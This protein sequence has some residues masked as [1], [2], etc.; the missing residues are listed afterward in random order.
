VNKNTLLFL[1]INIVLVTQIVIPIINRQVSLWT[2]CYYIL[3]CI[4]WRFTLW[5]KIRKVNKHLI[6]YNDLVFITVF[7]ITGITLLWYIDLNPFHFHYDEF[8]HA[9]TSYTLPKLADIDWFQGYPQDHVAQYPIIFYLLQKPFL[10][11]FGPSVTSVRMSTWP[12]IIGIIVYI[13]LLVKPIWGSIIAKLVVLGYIFFPGNLY[14]SSY[15]LHNIPS[16]LCLMGVLYH[17]YNFRKTNSSIHALWLGIWNALSLLYNT[18]SYIV[19]F[20]SFLLFGYWLIKQNTNYFKLQIIKSVLFTLIILFPFMVHA[21]FVHNYFTERVGQVNIFWGSRTD[22]NQPKTIVGGLTYTLLNHLHR[23]HKALYHPGIGGL[24]GYDFGRQSFFNKPDYCLILIGFIYVLCGLF[25]HRKY[26]YKLLLLFILLPIIFN[27]ILT[28]YP[29]AFHRLSVIYS[30]FAIIMVIPFNKILKIIKYYKF[31]L[32]GIFGSLFLLNFIHTNSMILHDRQYY[33]YSISLFN[34]LKSN[35]E[36]GSEIVISFSAP[37]LNYL[38]K[39][40]FFRTHGAYTFTNRSPEEIFQT[41]NGEPLILFESTPEVRQ[42]LMYSYPDHIFY[43][44]EDTDPDYIS[45]FGPKMRSL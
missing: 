12:Y 37:T 40:L 2:L 38:K 10:I 7:S 42:W 41:Y 34:Q 18:S 31:V 3:L 6:D 21:L 1:F 23:G 24:D 26:I 36:P 39:E 44:I 16:N 5:K 11:V 22:Y 20:I 4:F 28:I 32:F 45:F 14:F 43:N 30:L 8:I 27:Y 33:I 19:V 25:I 35:I 9:Y 17:I 13:Y 29:P 15:G